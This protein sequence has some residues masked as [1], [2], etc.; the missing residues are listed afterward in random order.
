MVGMRHDLSSGQIILWDGLG[1]CAQ[2]LGPHRR[3]RRTHYSCTAQ[4]GDS[5]DSLQRR[6]NVVVDLSLLAYNGSVLN[7]LT[8]RA[9]E[10]HMGKLVCP[11]RV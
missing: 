6:G 8:L 5:L 4:V 10:A 7:V 2:E 3:F 9:I 11:S 1:P